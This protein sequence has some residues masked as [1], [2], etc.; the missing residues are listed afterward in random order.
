MSKKFADLHI[1]STFSDGTLSPSEIIKK[2]D[3]EGLSAVAITDHDC[4]DAI[5]PALKEASLYGIEVIPGVELSCEYNSNEVHILGYIIDCKDIWFREKLKKLCQ[6]RIERVGKIVER[7]KLHG[8]DIG[9]DHIFKLSGCGSVGR[10]HIAQAMQEK[11]YVSNL[12]EA[13]NKYIGDKAPCYVGN[14]KLTPEDCIE[15]ID[16]IGGISILAHPGTLDTDELLSRLIDSGL[17]GIEVYHPDHRQSDVVNYLKIATRYKLLITGGSDFH[18]TR[19]EGVS[20]G[21]SK[22]PY[23]LLEK[24]KDARRS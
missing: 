7:L 10:L 5:E 13:F 12:K 16:R 6:R 4:V 24:L 1:H 20:L 15:M 9:T 14:F 22:I 2:A 18:G 17:D 23:E 21:S 11:G 3:K 19:K 8:V